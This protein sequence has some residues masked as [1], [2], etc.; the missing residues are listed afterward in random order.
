MSIEKGWTDFYIFSVD[1]VKAHYFPA[2]GNYHSRTQ[3][4]SSTVNYWKSF[5][6]L[7]LGDESTLFHPNSELLLF[8]QHLSYF[9]LWK[10]M[11]CKRQKSAENSRQDAW[12]CI[13][14]CVCMCTFHVLHKM[15][16]SKKFSLKDF[17]FFFSN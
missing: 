4:V 12:R 5:P 17:L 13:C 6:V 3:V 11:C 10:F 15:V 16:Y 7:S 8:I 9:I 1:E 2:P 14:M